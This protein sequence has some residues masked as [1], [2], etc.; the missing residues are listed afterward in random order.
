MLDGQLAEDVSE[1]RRQGE[2][3][4]AAACP[5]RVL[6]RAAAN[7]VLEGA[8]AAQAESMPARQIRGADL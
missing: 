7:P 6:S 2:V 1:V 8:P 5:L 3:D 4:A